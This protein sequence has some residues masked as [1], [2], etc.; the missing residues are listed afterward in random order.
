MLELLYNNCRRLISVSLFL[1]IL[2][3]SSGII[4]ASAQMAEDA[5]VVA[6]HGSNSAFSIF[7]NPAYIG[8]HLG[9]VVLLAVGYFLIRMHR[10]KGAS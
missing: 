10:R 5:Q 6:Y 2:V 3:G 9:F 4:H 1:F 7:Y 8:C